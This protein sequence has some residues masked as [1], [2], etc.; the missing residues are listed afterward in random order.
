MKKYTFIIFFFLTYCLSFSQTDS[1]TYYYNKGEIDKAITYGKN[2]ITYYENNNLNNS[3]NYII[4]LEWLL[5]LSLQKNDL[6]QSE[7]YCI[8]LQNNLDEFRNNQISLINSYY[9]IATFYFKKENYKCKS[10]AKSGL[11]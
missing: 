2:I 7:I 10:S 5:N 4:G 1:L 9:L 8:K 6:A 3:E 11:I